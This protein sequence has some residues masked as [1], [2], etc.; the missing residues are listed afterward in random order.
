MFKKMYI[1]EKI[2]FELKAKY[3]KIYTCTVI[4]TKTAPHSYKRIA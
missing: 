4:M 1:S 2:L 3:K